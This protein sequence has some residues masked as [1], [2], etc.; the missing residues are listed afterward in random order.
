MTNATA[1]MQKLVGNV[2][3]AMYKD[4]TVRKDQRFANRVH[5]DGTPTPFRSLHHAN[6]VT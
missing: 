4:N 2:L 3:L 6:L 5:W 1:V